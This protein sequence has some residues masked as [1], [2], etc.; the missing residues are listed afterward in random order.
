MFI[1]FESVVQFQFW[2]DFFDTQ[3]HLRCDYKGKADV[4]EE[5]LLVPCD[6]MNYGFKVHF[7]PLYLYRENGW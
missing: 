4:E 5:H 2:I 3:F 1:Q 7:T 6:E